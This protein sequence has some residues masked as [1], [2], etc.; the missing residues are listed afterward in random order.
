MTRQMLLF[1]ELN[2]QKVLFLFV[3]HVHGSSTYSR[4]NLWV[5]N[6]NQL[7]SIRK[8]RREDA[9]LL[10]LLWRL[11]SGAVGARRI[12]VEGTGAHRD[13]GPA[14]PHPPSPVPWTS[15]EAPPGAPKAWQSTA[16]CETHYIAQE[17]AKFPPTNP[18]R[19][20]RLPCNIAD[21]ID[22][23]N[24]CLQGLSFSL[25]VS[26]LSLWSCVNS[27]WQKTSLHLGVRPVKPRCVCDNSACRLQSL[28]PVGC[29]S[30]A[31]FAVSLS[32]ADVGFQKVLLLELWKDTAM[33]L[34]HPHC[35]RNHIRSLL[36]AVFLLG[37]PP[38]GCPLTFCCV[39]P[40]FK[41]LSSVTW[42]EAP[43]PQLSWD[44]PLASP[45]PTPAAGVLR[46]GQC[47][48]GG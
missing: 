32:R 1:Q 23:P 35:R 14:P 42:A 36:G 17:S 13:Q 28:Q 5:D 20:F 33:R 47:P 39:T 12:E 27:I 48:Q 19:G 41:S 15:P 31:T 21:P 34:R 10:Q 40:T 30:V 18:L 2:T 11:G 22:K 25:Q 16:S 6:M 7:G 37:D 8:P 46:V 4:F 44:R 38:P 9:G 29:V 24:R 43:G 3:S 45:R 26:V